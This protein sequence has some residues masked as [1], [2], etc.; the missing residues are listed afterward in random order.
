MNE[1]KFLLI[2]ITTPDAIIRL[3]KNKDEFNDIA[4]LCTQKE[5]HFSLKNFLVHQISVAG[6]C[7][8]CRMQV[9]PNICI[10]TSLQ[11]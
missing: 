9:S 6:N 8:G 7:Q 3:K 4:R 10:T 2:R 1:C 5:L 11:Y